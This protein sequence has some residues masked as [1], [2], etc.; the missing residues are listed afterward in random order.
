M[1]ALMTIFY[2][3][4]QPRDFRCLS[5]AVMSWYRHFG[6]KVGEHDSHILCSAAIQ[7]FNDGRTDVEDLTAGLLEMFPVPDLL[8]IN[9]PTSQ[10]IH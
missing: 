1:V 4:I 2:R 3:P 6:I 10:S 7:L 5:L 8:K 9:A